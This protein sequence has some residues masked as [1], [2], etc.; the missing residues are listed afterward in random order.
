[1]SVK[2]PLKAALASGSGKLPAG[3]IRRKVFA[4]DP[5]SFPTPAQP[6]EPTTPRGKRRRE[7]GRAN[8]KPPEMLV[9]GLA[10]R[11]HTHPGK[12]P[13]GPTTKGHL[14]TE[15]HSRLVAMTRAWKRNH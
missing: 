15:S 7:K 11:P 1:M 8:R 3:T 14:V 6:M 2:N 9:V 12:L 13:S 4:G 5:A 10:H